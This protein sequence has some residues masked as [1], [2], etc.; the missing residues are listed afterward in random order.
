[1]KKLTIAIDGPVGSGKS[2]V[3]RRVAELLGYA[4]LDSGAMYRALAWKALERGVPLE[5]EQELE[6]LARATRIDLETVSAAGQPASSKMRVRVDGVDVTT[7]DA[8]HRRTVHSAGFFEPHDG[9]RYDRAAVERFWPLRVGKQV[10]F[11]ERAP[12]G[13]WLHTLR[14]VRGEIVTVPAGSFDTFV[15]ER[16]TSGL[17]RTRFFATY[18]YW[19]A[20]AAGAIVRAEIR[21]AGTSPAP[22]EAEILGRPI[23]ELENLPTAGGT[24]AGDSGQPTPPHR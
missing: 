10:T 15:V 21:Q 12:D 1:M 2:S 9:G 5:S 4:Y 7:V 20:P 3:A 17:G 6:A 13:D 22:I 11:V 23:A 14:A 18:T 16:A 24:V 8:L 19:Y